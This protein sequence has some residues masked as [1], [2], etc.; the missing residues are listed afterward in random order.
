MDKENKEITVEL[1]PDDVSISWDETPEIPTLK[2]A[3]PSKRKL[4][5]EEFNAICD[6]AGFGNPKTYPELPADQEDTVKGMSIEEFKAIIA[7]AAN[8]APDPSLPPKPHQGQRNGQGEASGNDPL[9]LREAWLREA[10]NRM[11]G[12]VGE[13]VVAGVSCGYGMGGT[14]SKKGWSVH[15]GVDGRKQIFIHPNLASAE[16]VLPKLQ[17]ALMEAYGA[18]Y[19]N[20][21]LGGIAAAM[22][23][24]L[25]NKLEVAEEKKDSVRQIKCQ[26]PCCRYTVRTTRKWLKHGAPFC[27]TPHPIADMI[28]GLVFVRQIDQQ[29]MARYQLVIKE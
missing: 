23:P 20:V 10:C 11:G 7:S 12:R 14:R 19:W 15:D 21:D 29:E 16:E 3:K 28:S 13:Q 1:G 18:K 22:L 2:D 17:D 27:P 25:Q 6:K 24:Y 9:K 26:C 8:K 4:T 5:K